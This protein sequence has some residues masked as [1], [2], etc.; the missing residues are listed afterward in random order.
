MSDPEPTPRGIRRL[1]AKFPKLGGGTGKKVTR[2]ITILA[3]MVLS[4]IIGVLMSNAWVASKEAVAKHPYLAVVL[5]QKSIDFPIPRD[6]LRG[7]QSAYSSG[8]TYME[9]RSGRQ[10][11]IRVLEDLGSADE[12]SR[13]AA[14][15]AEDPECILVIGNS[16]STLTD[17][18]LNIFLRSTDPPTYILPIAT[19]ND[20]L[21][22]ARTAGHG[23]VLRMVPDNARQAEVIQRLVRSLAPRQRVAIYGDQE[24]SSYSLDLSRDIASRIRTNGGK[25]VI[26]EMIGQTNSFLRSMPSWE[27]PDSAPDVIIYVGVAHHGLLLIDQL[28]EADIK[29]PIIFTDGCMVGDL[30]K[31]I[32]RIQNRAFVLSPVGGEK[33]SDQMPTYEPIGKDAYS[34]ATTILGMCDDVARAGLRKCV[35][36]NK[37]RIQLLNGFA[38]EY[39]FAADGN[40]VSMNYKVYE[41]TSGHLK[42][43]VDN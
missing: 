35:E 25:I 42:P 18:T 36:I 12:A 32:D 37:E 24:N 40:N 29:V 34:L 38:G 7:F 10:V 21:V 31:N 6:F 33:L 23:A 13:I 3:G 22:K 39:R 2:W 16:N 5:S 19:A 17:T 9:T 41:I 8:K 27:R 4:G 14:R 20:L 30:L 43:A 1:L 15:L 11:D 26:E 28:S